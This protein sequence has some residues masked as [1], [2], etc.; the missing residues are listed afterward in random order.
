LAAL[1]KMPNVV[2]SLLMQCILVQKIK[3]SLI[4]A[5]GMTSIKEKKIETYWRTQQTRFR[6]DPVRIDKSYSL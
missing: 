2:I 1:K 3:V 5:D 4:F 6:E